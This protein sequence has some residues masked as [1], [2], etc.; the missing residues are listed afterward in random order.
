M[1]SGV[2]VTELLNLVRIY[3]F[4]KREFSDGY[5]FKGESHDFYEVVCALE[6]EMIITAGKSVFTLRGGEI[7]IHPPGEFHAF[8]VGK[9]GARAI[10]FSFSASHFPSV[11]GKVFSV[12]KS[13]LQTLEDIYETIIDI[14]VMNENNSIPESLN[15]GMEIEAAL[16]VKRL[17]ALLLGTLATGKNIKTVSG[18]GKSELFAN[19]LSVMEKHISDGI[20]AEQIAALCGISVPTLEN[21]VRKYLSCGAITH[22]NS[23]RMQRAHTL[24]RS[25]AGVGE[26]AEELG[27]SNQNYFSSRFKKYYGYPPSVLK[28]KG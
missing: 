16:C 19:I 28:S 21:T 12:G 20:S 27:F 8:R 25:G 24:L 9:G 7:T 2:R 3:S 11:M 22:Y 10:I 23:L 13:E 26:V 1:L 4:F 14:Y 15:D 18:Y 6:G 5:F 17:E